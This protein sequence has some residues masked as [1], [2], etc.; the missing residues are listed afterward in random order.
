MFELMK[1]RNFMVSGS[2]FLIVLVLAFVCILGKP[3]ENDS[4]F[5][6]V[7]SYGL[8]G[9]FPFIW[10]FLQFKKQ[11]KMESSLMS[12]K[13][14]LKHLPLILLLVIILIA[15]SLGVYWLTNYLLSFIA[16]HY[17]ERSLADDVPM[18]S[19]LIEYM[20]LA[21]NICFIGP[22]AE[23]FIFRG[24]LLKRLSTKLNLLISAIITN[25]LFGIFHSDI[26]GAF[27][28]GFVLSILYIKTSNFLISISLHVLNNTILTLLSIYL[29]NY[30]DFTNII[31]I[32]DLHTKMIPNLIMFVLSTFLIIIYIKR[33]INFLYQKNS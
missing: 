19:N 24:L 12:A 28:F 11:K 32:E 33:N 27:V 10:F 29:P 7:F 5:Y 8:L 23:E 31:N 1:I 20:L 30:P 21:I 15:F 16:P 18:S 13:G 22:I 3:S 9:V 4:I 17:V 25:L 6:I 14:V 2:I 26:I